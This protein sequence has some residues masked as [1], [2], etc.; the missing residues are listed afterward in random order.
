M[1]PKP[2]IRAYKVSSP[3]GDAVLVFAP[4][5]SIAKGMVSNTTAVGGFEYCE[6]SARLYPKAEPYSNGQMH[7]LWGHMLRA[8]RIY[9]DLGWKLH[10]EPACEAC[11]RGEF[12]SIPES[13]VKYRDDIEQDNLCVECYLQER[14]S[15]KQ[16]LKTQ[17]KKA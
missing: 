13:I 11:G 16:Q 10:D 14:E 3:F 12:D 9:Y 7:V 8:D 6:L 15:R 4:K 17:N 5:A 1:K 2:K